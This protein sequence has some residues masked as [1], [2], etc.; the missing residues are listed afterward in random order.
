MTNALLATRHNSGWMFSNITSKSN[1]KP[2]K[3]GVI[4]SS[5]IVIGL[6]A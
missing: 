3:T 5:P 2:G 1:M 6:E 4:T